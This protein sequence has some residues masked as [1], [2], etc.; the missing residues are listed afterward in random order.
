[1]MT[2]ALLSVGITGAFSFTVA[3]TKRSVIYTSKTTLT[4][5][6]RSEALPITRSPAG[7]GMVK[8]AE[9]VVRAERRVDSA[10]TLVRVCLPQ[11][12]AV[13]VLPSRLFVSEEDIGVCAHFLENGSAYRR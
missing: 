10:A 13:H 1:M 8:G 5:T 2:T 9:N 12:A 3:N 4:L 11:A 6:I 7:Q